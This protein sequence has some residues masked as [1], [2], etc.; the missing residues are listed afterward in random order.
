MALAMSVPPPSWTLISVSTG[1][2]IRSV[3]S[4]TAVSKIT[5]WVVSMGS[6]AKMP[7]ITAAWMTLE[8]MEPLSSTAMITCQGLRRRTRP[9]K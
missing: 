6:L 4:T 1:S 2:S 9:L 5:R 3:R 7:A 8:S